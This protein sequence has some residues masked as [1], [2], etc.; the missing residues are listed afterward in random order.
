MNDAYALEYCATNTSADWCF[1]LMDDVYV[2][3]EGIEW[4]LKWLAS[5]DD[6]RTTAMVFGNCMPTASCEFYLQ[7]G[8]G[9]GFSR[10]AAQMMVDVKQDWI[11]SINTVEDFHITQFIRHL[12]VPSWKCESPFFT[13]HFMRWALWLRW[14]WH[15]R[16]YFM[17][18]PL[19]LQKEAVCA[20]SLYPYHKVVFVHSLRTHM[21]QDRWHTWM[22]AAPRTTMFFYSGSGY[23]ICEA[24]PGQMEAALRRIVSG[25]INTSAL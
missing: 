4:M 16:Q 17:P 24:Q 19:R 9:Y 5:L 18:C 3:E 25:F 1:R 12:D 20:H 23:Q 15:S 10:R 14:N 8:S 7:G 13:G 11:T 22:K 2:N 6:P 21:T